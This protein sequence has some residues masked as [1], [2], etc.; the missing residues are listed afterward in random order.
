[1]DR[2]WQR[3]QEHVALSTAA[4]LVY[5]QIQQARPDAADATQFSRLLDRVAQAIST[6]TAIYIA[7]PSTG[8]NRELS[9]L[10]LLDCRFRRGATILVMNGKEYR[11]LSVRRGDLHA[12]IAIL[13]RAG[14]RFRE[15]E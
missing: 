8:G 9:R 6:V 1:M 5:H 2:A 3:S 15:G 12:A 14:V 4:A 11:G 10:E 7:E 13:R